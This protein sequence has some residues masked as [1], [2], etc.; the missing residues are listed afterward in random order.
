[1][2][3]LNWRAVAELMG[4]SAIVA[5]L[6]FVGVQLRQDREVALVGIGQAGSSTTAEIRVA[7]AENADVWAKSNNGESLTDAEKLVMENLIESWFRQSVTD[8]LERRRIGEEG[9]LSTAIF[10]MM[11]YKN[12]GARQI[13]MQLRDDNVRLLNQIRP[14][15]K[16]YGALYDE[17][18]SDL[19][20]LDQANAD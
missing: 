10:A 11:L 1:M 12:P 3:R 19:K 8:A 4:I 17:V 7:V 18:L 15:A 16:F 6:I 13:W 2:D 9:G 14:N 20:L 5:S